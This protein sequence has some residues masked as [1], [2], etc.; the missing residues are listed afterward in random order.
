M[1]LGG[2]FGS[3]LMTTI[4]EE[5]GLTYGITAAL[6]GSQ[7][8]AYL[9][10]SAQCDK[11]FTA[12]VLDETRNELR[13]L[14]TDPPRGEELQRLKLHAQSALAEMLDTPQSIATYYITE[15]LV[16]TPTNYYDMQQDSID[17]FGPDKCAA[18]AE[19]YLNPDKLLTA[20]A[21]AS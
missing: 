21:G 8:G 5:K 19:K 11:S 7:E 14:V 4:R 10:I 18:L 20:I 9:K 3:R 6:I 17:A 13:R 15:L 2:Y 16:N 1:A 12:A